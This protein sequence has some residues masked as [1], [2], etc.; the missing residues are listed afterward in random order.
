VSATPIELGEAKRE[1]YA[2]EMHGALQ[3][4]DGTLAN[5]KGVLTRDRIDFRKFQRAEDA[6]MLTLEL[7]DVVLPGD[8][9]RVRVKPS[10]GNPKVR[11]ILNPLA[12]GDKL[13][14]ALTRDEQP[15]WQAGEFMLAPGVWRVTAHAEGAAPVS[16]LVVVAAA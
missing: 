1:V 15:R 6:V 14:E 5:L 13:D 12:G 10:E 7:D 4:A 3:N 9:L 8:A 2:A 11:V 16:D